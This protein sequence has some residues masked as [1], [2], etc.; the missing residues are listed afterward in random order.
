MKTIDIRDVAFT[1][2]VRHT[3]PQEILTAHKTFKESR[4]TEQ[5]MNTLKIYRTLDAIYDSLKI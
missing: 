4:T 5:R 2:I 1:V 3:V